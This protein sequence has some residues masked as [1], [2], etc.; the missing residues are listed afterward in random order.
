M[1]DKVKAVGSRASVMHGSAMKTSGGLTASDLK[2]NSNGR[3]VSK[4]KSEMGKRLYSK[5]GLTPGSKE[6]LAKIRRK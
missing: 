4:A 3:I 2:Y 6:F 5:N 1:P